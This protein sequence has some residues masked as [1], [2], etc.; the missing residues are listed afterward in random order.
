[1]IAM[2][3]R[4]DIGGDAQQIGSVNTDFAAETF[5][6]VLLPIW[7]AAYKYDGKSYRFVVNGQSGR[8]HGDRPYSAWKIALAVILGLIILAAGLWIA[9]QQGY[10]QIGSGSTGFPMPGG[11]DLPERYSL[12]G[13][14]PSGGGYVIRGY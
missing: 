8:V 6:Q 3:V 10:V 4:R 11:F 1:M 2:D 14:L 5:K 12:P 9:Q 13:G 7:L